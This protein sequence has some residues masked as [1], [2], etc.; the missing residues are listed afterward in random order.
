MNTIGLC[1]PEKL[2]Q[3]FHVNILN[4][5]THARTY[6]HMRKHTHTRPHTHSHRECLPIAL[7]DTLLL[8]ASNTVGVALTG[9]VT[10]LL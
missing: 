7:T 9:R 6:T 1:M 10:V 8:G 3:S 4:T 2:I 5:L